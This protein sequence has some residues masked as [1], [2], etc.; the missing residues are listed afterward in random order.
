MLKQFGLESYCLEDISFLDQIR[1]L[2]QAKLLIS[3]HGAG[4]TNM[5][6]MPAGSRVIE[7]RKENDCINN[8]YFSLANALGLD[9]LYLLTKP[10][11]D[12]HNSDVMIDSDQLKSLL[13]K[14]CD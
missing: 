12:D 3:N 1:L 2:A 10:L 14:Y 5:L 6:F 13:E 4:L 11:K 9:Y 8:C 7:F